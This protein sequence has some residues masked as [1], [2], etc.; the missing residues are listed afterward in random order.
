MGHK[1]CIDPLF[2]LLIS[3][4]VVLIHLT[5][6]YKNKNCILGH[7]PLFCTVMNIKLFCD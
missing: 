6:R 1:I 4:F 7:A 2:S 5:Y 3:P